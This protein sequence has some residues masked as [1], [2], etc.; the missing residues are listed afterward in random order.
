M[1][2]SDDARRDAIHSSLMSIRRV[3]APSLFFARRHRHRRTQ[4]RGRGNPLPS[5]IYT[6]RLSP[7]RDF[8]GELISFSINKFHSGR[9]GPVRPLTRQFSQIPVYFSFE[10]LVLD[11]VVIFKKSVH[12][13]FHLLL[14]LQQTNCKWEFFSYLNISAG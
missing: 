14:L 12:A 11:S 7:E 8:E 6:S 13:V 1:R 9:H 5:N 4:K 2:P 10:F 3:A